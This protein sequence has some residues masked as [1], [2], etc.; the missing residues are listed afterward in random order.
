MSNRIDHEQYGRG[1][2]GGGQAEGPAEG[3][4]GMAGEHPSSARLPTPDAARR[5]G[6]RP[7]GEGPGQLGEPEIAG[8]SEVPQEVEG[9]VHGEAAALGKL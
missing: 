4:P 1:S 3:E 2:C 5:K 7:P 6:V 9:L 8:T